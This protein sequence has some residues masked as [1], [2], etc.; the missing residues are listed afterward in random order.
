MKLGYHGTSLENAQGIL[1]EGYKN[2]TTRFWSVSTGNMHVFDSDYAYAIDLASTQSIS[3]ALCSP[4]L[5]RA[6][7]IV[8]ITNKKLKE[9]T[10]C[11]NIEGAFEI[12]D[13]VVPEDIIAI[14]SDIE[15]LNPI[16]RVLH[17][18]AQKKMH[19]K[20]FYNYDVMKLTK[21]EEELYNILHE[22][23]TNPN[24]K[25]KMKVS[26]IKEGSKVKEETIETII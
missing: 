15:P 24:Y 22:V 19:K 20:S 6:L 11:D 26:Y 12:V 14:Y 5:K 21:E 10:F 16:L 13:K 17:K 23:K 1:N 9:D 3:A 2:T 8:D 4:S 7:V 25:P 18:V